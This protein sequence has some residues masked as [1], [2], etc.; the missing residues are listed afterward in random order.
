MMISVL[1]IRIYIHNGDSDDDDYACYE[2]D[3]IHGGIIFTSSPSISTVITY[4]FLI[5][6]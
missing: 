2:A 3:D 5:M 4:K 1:L 6:Q